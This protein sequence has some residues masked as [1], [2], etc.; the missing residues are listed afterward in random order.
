MVTREPLGNLEPLYGNVRR[1]ATKGF[2]KFLILEEQEK[3]EKEEWEGGSR[4]SAR[5]WQTDEIRSHEKLGDA[6]EKRVRRRSSSFRYWEGI[7]GE[8]VG[9]NRIDNWTNELNPFAEDIVSCSNT[10]DRLSIVTRSSIGP[11]ETG[12]LSFIIN[13]LVYIHPSFSIFFLFFL[14]HFIRI[15]LKHEFTQSS[16]YSIS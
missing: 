2:S 3:R 8:S 12:I 16:N 1:T 5:H 9:M 14:F 6:W 15:A 4:Q 7:R 11:S 10:V 13:N